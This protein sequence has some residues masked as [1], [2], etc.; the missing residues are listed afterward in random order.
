MTAL[1]DEDLPEGN[2]PPLEGW[3][4]IFSP[5]S[6]KW[7]VP[8]STDTGTPRYPCTGQPLRHPC[9]EYSSLQ[10]SSVAQSLNASLHPNHG[11]GRFKCTK[12][13]LW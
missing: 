12:S 6:I 10:W 8:R 5:G 3:R 2:P 11:F 1:G 7:L 4:F 9:T 13:T